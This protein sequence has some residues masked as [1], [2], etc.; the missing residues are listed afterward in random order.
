MVHS[1]SSP[2][3]N[4]NVNVNQNAGNPP[5]PGVDPNVA[6][7]VDMFHKADAILKA[8]QT[9][10]SIRELQPFDGNPVK[11]HSFIRAV[12]ILMPFIE[13]LRNTPFEQVYLQSIR[14]KIVGDADQVLE[15]YGTSLMWDDIKANLIAYY[16]HKRDVVTQ[17]NYFKCNKWDQLKS[18]IAK[19]NICF[20]C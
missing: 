7:T 20:R 2:T 1:Q 17:G 12:E 6:Q 4:P 13:P 11:L 5:V 16:N 14:A 18:F 15:I 19:C 10:Q 8:M 9:A 3:P